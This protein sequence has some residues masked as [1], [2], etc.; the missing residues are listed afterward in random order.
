MLINGWRGFA[1]FQQK[2][3]LLSS[4][5]QVKMIQLSLPTSPP[6]ATR[7]SRQQTCLQ[8]PEPPQSSLPSLSLSLSLRLAK[9]YWLCLYLCKS[10]PQWGQGVRPQ[11]NFIV[12]NCENFAVSKTYLSS[13]RYR[14][15]TLFIFSVYK[16]LGFGPKELS[17]EK[18]ETTSFGFAKVGGDHLSR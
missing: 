11:P 18:N 2:S 9:V 12:C 17:R 15:L 13:T 14:P 10:S 8:L 3:S 4:E 16:T 7:S 5:N 6:A 1:C